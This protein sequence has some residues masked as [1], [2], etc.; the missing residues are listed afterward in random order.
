MQGRTLFTYISKLYL[1]PNFGNFINLKQNKNRNDMKAKGSQ[2]TGGRAKGTPN[3]L[4]N[5]LRTWINDLLNE[6]RAQFA[7]DLKKLEPQQ[8]VSIFEKLLCYA[9]PKMHSV[10]AK[11]DLDK[12]SDEQVNVVINQLNKDIDNE[13]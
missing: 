8:R 6:N 10:E 2:K 5:D 4:T 11:I 9:I 3:K 13:H 12:L 7:A 1:L